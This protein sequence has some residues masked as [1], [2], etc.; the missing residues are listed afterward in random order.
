MSVKIWDKISPINGDPAESFLKRRSE[1]QTENCILLIDDATERITMTELPSALRANYKLDSGLSDYEVGVWYEKYLKEQ[2][3]KYEEDA[4][5]EEAKR[6]S[7]EE[8]LALL[9]DIVLNNGGV[10]L[11][12]NK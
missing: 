4:K 1:F 6:N 3:A 11:D 7:V 10:V 5:K 2:Q 12:G 9:E 8:R